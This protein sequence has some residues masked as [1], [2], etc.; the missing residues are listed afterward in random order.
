MKRQTRHV[1]PV[2][3]TATLMIS[4]LLLVSIAPL[5]SAAQTP[6]FPSASQ[7]S[8]TE[9]MSFDVTAGGEE[10]DSMDIEQRRDA[11]RIPEEVYKNMSTEALLLTIINN[12]FLVGMSAFSYLYN[13]VEFQAKVYPELAE[14]LGREDFSD[15]VARCL[16][17]Y[18]D[19]SPEDDLLAWGAGSVLRDLDKYASASEYEK[20][21]MGY[22]HSR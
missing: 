21:L 13:G 6:D 14:L 4:V 19:V 5:A 22:L 3:R 11:F 8:I 17:S 16:A 15:T 7:Y 1:S 9:K 18:P 20:E 10:W 12:P 2:V